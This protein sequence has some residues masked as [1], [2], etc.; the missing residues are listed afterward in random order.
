MGQGLDRSEGRS[1][2]VPFHWWMLLGFCAFVA[3]AVTGYATFGLHPEWLAGLPPH[4]AEFHGKAFV[5]FSRG[6]IW[7]SGLVLAVGLVTFTGWVWVP[8][9][10]AL[11][12]LSLA[13]ELAGTT[14]G[15]PFGP[16]SYTGFLGMKWWDHVPIVIPLSWFTMALPGYAMAQ[17][18]VPHVGSRFKRIALA[19]YLLVAWDLSLD[20]AMSF[21]TKYWVW[22]AEGP[23]YGM[24]LLNLFGWYFT[25]VVLMSALEALGA[26]RWTP[27]LPIRWVTCYYLAV[28]ILPVGMCAAA[29]LW[30][31]LLLSTISILAVLVPYWKPLWSQA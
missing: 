24:P 10:L 16:Y 18:I 9:F 17:R 22:G 19:S 11:Y 23:Y 3:V 15:L 31:A 1:M 26:F 4:L 13:S 5:L 14:V 25:G 29:G 30:L 2:K 27:R 21:L 20:P 8:A 12:G 7:L 28:L 6:Q